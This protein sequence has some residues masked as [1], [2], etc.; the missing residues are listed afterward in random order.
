MAPELI[1]LFPLQ[2]VLFPQLPLPLHIFEPRYRE[3]IAACLERHAEFGVIL[4]G[5]GGL[6]PVGCTAGIIEVVKKYEDGRLDIATVGRRRFRV[7]ELVEE[8]AYLQGRVE[9]LLDED[10]PGEKGVPAEPLL[11]LY[12]EI[13]SLLAGQA[14]PEQQ[15]NPEQVSFQVAGVLPLELAYKQELLELTSEGERRESLLKHLQEFAARLRRMKKMKAV[16]SGN[17]HGGHVN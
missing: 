2:V 13:L 11:A 4:A 7:I 5:A 6:A 16:A 10:V 12:E 14:P 8:R 17:S 3:M 15:L 9:F 1:P